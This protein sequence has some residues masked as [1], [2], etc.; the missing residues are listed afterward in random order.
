MMAVVTTVVMMMM[1]RLCKRC[2]RH[3][4]KQGKEENCFL[5]T[6]HCSRSS[7]NRRL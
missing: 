6:S 4:E 7:M 5:H 2:G 1:G 3:T